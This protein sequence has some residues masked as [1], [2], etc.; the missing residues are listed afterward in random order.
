[1]RA[2]HHPSTERVLAYCYQML[3]Q[4]SWENEREK[5]K[6]AQPRNSLSQETVVERKASKT[7]LCILRELQERKYVKTH[8]TRT[9]IYERNMKE[10]VRHAYLQYNIMWEMK[11]HT[12]IARSAFARQPSFWSTLVKVFLSIMRD[13]KF[14]FEWPIVMYR[15]YKGIQ[16]I[17]QKYQ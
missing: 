1:M 8:S 17:R 11:N 16:R 15:M 2:D 5:Q 14:R 12:N 3:K 9:L 13:S 4:R 10:H 6:L 7:R